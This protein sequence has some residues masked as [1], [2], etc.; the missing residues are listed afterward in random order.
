MVQGYRTL[1]CAKANISH[2]R[3]QKEGKG[4]LRPF[5]TISIS[6][7]DKN[8]QCLAD[9]VDECHIKYEEKPQATGTLMA[10]LEPLPPSGFVC[11]CSSNV[12]VAEVPE[13]GGTD[14]FRSFRRP[15]RRGVR[16]PRHF[17]SK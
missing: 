9:G 12:A 6:H 13:L 8:E 1:T 7:Q 11:P 14:V 16:I 3:S 15:T 5:K 4:F 2:L 17:P 10:W